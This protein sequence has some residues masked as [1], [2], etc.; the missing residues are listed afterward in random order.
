MESKKVLKMRVQKTLD[1]I[2]EQYPS[3]MFDYRR[4]NQKQA[5]DRL[6]EERRFIGCTNV[7]EDEWKE[8]AG[9]AFRKWLVERS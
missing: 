6:W 8:A 5:A 1:K 9:D 4:L 7:E 2:A 3:L